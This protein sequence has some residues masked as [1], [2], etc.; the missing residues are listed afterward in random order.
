MTK[1]I[2]SLV[3]AA[4]ALFSIM[5]VP[6]Y[7]KNTY[8]RFR[9]ADKQS[10]SSSWGKATKDDGDIYAYITPHRGID[11]FVSKGAVV[12][13]RVRDRFENYATEYIECRTYKKYTPRYLNGKAVAGDDYLLFANVEST[14]GYPVRMGGL[15]CP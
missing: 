9:L 1:K 8:F 15:W 13:M 7:A 11:D 3:L 10:H 2:L 5:S 12:N 4:C 14:N 6:V